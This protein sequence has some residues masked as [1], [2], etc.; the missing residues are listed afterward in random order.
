MSLPAFCCGFDFQL[1]P[2]NVSTD[3]P[4]IVRELAGIRFDTLCV[5]VPLNALEPDVQI[6][7]QTWFR[8][9]DHTSLNHF[10]GTIAEITHCGF[11]EISDR[12]AV[13]WTLPE[14]GAHPPD[15]P[16]DSKVISRGNEGHDM[17]DS[18][19][20]TQDDVLDVFEQLDDPTESL[21]T[22]EVADASDCSRR[23]AYDRLS[24]LADSGRIRT[25]KV[26]A[27]VRIWWHPHGDETQSQSDDQSQAVPELTDEHVLELEFHSEQLGQAV[28]EA[29]GTNVQ[30]CVDGVIFR[31]DGTQLQYWTITDMAENTFVEIITDRS[32]VLDTRLLST[33]ADTFRMELLTTSDSLFA[34]F[35][36]FDGHTEAVSLDDDRVKFIGW[37]PTTVDV[38][39]VAAAARD[40]FPDLELTAQHLVSTPRLFRTVVEDR[41]T[42]RQ[43]MA[44]RIAYHA[45]YFNRQRT[46]SGDE[47]AT[48]MGVSRQTFHHHLREAE[49][50]V[51][52]ALMDGFSDDQGQVHSDGTSISD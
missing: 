17:T 45:G 52:Q 39:A 28:L 16:T 22:S 18:G 50:L 48:R 11:Q 36:T 38:D 3:R 47:L 12:T 44:L 7:A 27:Q 35:D 5:Q 23:P 1:S 13:S 8:P 20:I 51:F 43:W 37:F 26:G 4:P 31:D 40:V 42:D 15:T 19:R 21:S 6:V 41:L 29:G 30:I 24:A 34:A 14:C 32:T 49:H 46:S 10:I 33:V 2:S 25:K 9:D